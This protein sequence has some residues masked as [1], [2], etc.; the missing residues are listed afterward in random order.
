M[1]ASFENNDDEAS[2]LNEVETRRYRIIVGSLLHLAF[3][4]RLDLC[5]AGSILASHV[6]KAKQE[7][8][9]RGAC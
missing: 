2:L 8:L 6:E 3:N 9:R 5:V 1:A 4:T 7:R